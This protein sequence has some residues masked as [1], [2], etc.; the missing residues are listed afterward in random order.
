MAPF[1][2][3]LSWGQPEILNKSA[4]T[5]YAR[6]GHP[7][8]QKG[9]MQITGEASAGLVWY[10]NGLMAPILHVQRGRSYTFRV[11][12]GNEFDKSYRF[13]HPFYITDEPYGGYLLQNATQRQQQ[14]VFAGLQFER[15]PGEVPSKGQSKGTASNNHGKEQKSTRPHV[16][17]ILQMI[18][19][20]A[21]NS[22]GRLCAWLP[23]SNNDIRKAESHHSFAQFRAKL[24]YSCSPNGQPGI[25]QWS[26]KKW[27]ALLMWCIIRAILNGTWDG[28]H[29]KIREV[30]ISA[31]LVIVR[32]QSA[33]TKLVLIY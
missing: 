21:P 27:L 13:Y 7:G 28:I 4:T 16:A 6:L 20:P 18:G 26:P 1:L 31:I 29:N 14:K 5:F 17:Q 30:F 32:L 2:G 9:Y 15:A 25:I 33:G 12:G 8:V 11:E 24:D 3:S 22:V 19:K 10:I 23:K